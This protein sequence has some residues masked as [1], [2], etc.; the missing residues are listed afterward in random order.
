MYKIICT[1]INA[2]KDRIVSLV[3]RDETSS[4]VYQL[5]VQLFPLSEDVANLGNG[6]KGK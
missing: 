3:H 2:F 1:E 6:Q 4:A 5:N